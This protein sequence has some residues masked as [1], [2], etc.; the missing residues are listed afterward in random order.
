MQQARCPSPPHG[1]AAAGTTAIPIHVTRRSPIVARVY[2]RAI[3][4]ACCLDPQPMS[5]SLSLGGLYCE[6]TVHPRGA[7]RTAR[8]AP[9]LF[10]VR[11]KIDGSSRT[12]WRDHSARRANARCTIAPLMRA[13]SRVAP[14]G[15]AAAAPTSRSESPHPSRGARPVRRDWVSHQRTARGTRGSTAGK[16]R[17]PRWRNAQV[18]PSCWGEGRDLAGRGP[19]PKRSIRVQ[20]V[21]PALPLVPRRR[22]S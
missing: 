7:A 2:A 5:V 8:E 6:G 3:R 15:T 1:D 14:P 21:S 19:G 16:R 20:S 12:C 22:I 11:I 13:L 18:V 17:R 4:C 10:W 9:L